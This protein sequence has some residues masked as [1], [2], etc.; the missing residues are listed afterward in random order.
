MSLGHVIFLENLLVLFTDFFSTFVTSPV[1]PMITGM[2]KDLIF[3]IHW[4]S[5][6]LCFLLYNIPIW[7][8]YKAY[9]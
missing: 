7:W 8:N 5:I 9:Q 1:A 4:I 6:L 2:T 3:Y